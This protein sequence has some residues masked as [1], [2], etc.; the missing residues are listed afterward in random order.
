MYLQHMVEDFFFFLENVSLGHVFPLDCC[1]K[2]CFSL[3]IFT[4]FS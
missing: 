3:N 2:K 4:A 1:I